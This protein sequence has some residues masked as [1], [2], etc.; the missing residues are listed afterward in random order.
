[1]IDRPGVAK[2]QLAF[3]YGIHM[4]VGAPLARLEGEI[5]FNR[6]FDRLPNLR[7]AGGENRH[8]PIMNQR[9]PLEV[10]VAWDPA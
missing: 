5:A 9:A 2:H 4:C 8:I 7:L 6:L 10:H 3:G 1:M